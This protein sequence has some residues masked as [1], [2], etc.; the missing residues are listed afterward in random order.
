M[1]KKNLAIFIY[2]LAGG[3]AERIVSDL[4]LHLHNDFNV[5]LVLM[6]SRIDYEVKG[7]EKVVYLEKSSPNEHGIKKLL[8]LPL[9]AYRYYK[10]CKKSDTD[11]TLS[12]LTRPNYIALISK[13]FGNSSKIIISEHSYPSKM[14]EGSGAQSQINRMLIRWLY[15]KADA[16]IAISKKVVSDLESNFH[17]DPSKMVQIYNPFDIERVIEKSKEPVEFDFSKY[18]F[19]TVGRLDS[20][21]NHA[22]QIEAF[23]LLEDKNTQLIILGKGENED[24][25]QKMI[26]TLH[27]T[28]RVFMLGFDA[29]PYKYLSRSDTFILS[30]NYEGLP[31]VILEA[32]SCKLAIIS[33]DCPSGPREIL[34]PASKV[35]N[36][37]LDTLEIAEYGILIPL[38][39]REY[40]KEAMTKMI[41][42]KPLYEKYCNR[43]ESRAED[44]ALDKIIPQYRDILN[45]SF[46]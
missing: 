19:I 11:V 2:S 31:M 37:L 27:L 15:S 40:L 36:R 8:K 33:T 16:I 32:L 7:V 30:S 20:G 43:S 14:Y 34:A 24:T 3:G 12:L 42:D 44:F 29:N 46:S 26:E 1:K 13:N 18:T 5:T 25:L 22:L 4:T 10:F 9:L 6:C 39:H 38:N 41:E 17:I 35:P 21:K 23:S 28:N 45:K